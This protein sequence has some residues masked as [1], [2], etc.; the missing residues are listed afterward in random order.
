MDVTT[1]AIQ[2]GEKCGIG[3]S[4]DPFYSE[5]NQRHLRA[6]AERIA[7]GK[8]TFVT[9]TMEELEAMAE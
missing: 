4:Q 2:F 9:K 8:A 7:S 6:V 3:Q 1:S 5:A